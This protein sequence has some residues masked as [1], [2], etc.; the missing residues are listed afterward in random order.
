MYDLTKR[1]PIQGTRC[2][3]ALLWV[4]GWISVGVGAVDARTG[5][6]ADQPYADRPLL[7]VLEELRARGLTIFFTSQLIQGD[8]R[9]AWE[10]TATDPAAMLDEILAP[11][12]LTTEDGPGGRRVVI[13]A[14][15]P[16]R[17]RGL[18]LQ[19]SNGAPIPGVQVLLPEYGLETFTDA[20]G[21]FLLEDTPAGVHVVE[22]RS[23]GFIVQ[24]VDAVKVFEHGLSQVHFI[25]DAAPMAL[26]EIVVTPSQLSIL[27]EEPVT[28]LDLNRD[29]FLALP[30]LGD[31][32]F[33]TFTLLPGISGEETSARFNIRGGR[34]DEVLVLLDRV[35][36]FEPYHLKDFNGALS[37]V[38]PRALQEVNLLT[39]GFPAQYGDRMSGVLD[40]SSV[41]GTTQRRTHFALN[42]LTAEASRAESFD[43]GRG[44]WLAS[45]RGGTLEFTLDL[46]DQ[47]DRPTYWDI[48]TKG[49]YQLKPNQRIGMRLLHSADAL[50]L[51]TLEESDSE[52]YATSYGNSYLWLDYQSILGEDLF[53]DTLFSV[54][55]VRRD[56]QGREVDLE[57]EEGFVITDN[58]DFDVLGF[59]QDW[60]LRLGEQHYVR[61][62]F[63]ARRLEASYDYSNRFDTEDPF[64]EFRSEPRASATDFEGIFEGEQYSAYLT[65][66]IRWQ[67]NLT[68][69]LGLRYDENSV[70]GDRDFSPR[71]NLLYNAGDRSSLRLAWGLFFQSQ[72]PYELQVEDGETQLAESERT[73]HW[74]LGYE[75]AFTLGP[76]SRDMLL[77]IEAYRRDTDNPRVRFE[78][79]F[80]P[81]SNFPEVDIDRFRIAPESSE[82]HGI[83]VFLRG[84]ASR[85][86]DFW[87]SYAY[88]RV[89]DRLG[90]RDVP[91]RIDQPHTVNLDFH[92]RP[93]DR[94]SLNLGWRYHTGWP[95]TAL[96]GQPVEGGDDDE[97]TAVL[98]P[99]NGER[100][101]T[102]HRLDLR[103]SRQWQLR[104][105]T[106]DLFIDVQN[107]YDR[108][109]VAGIDLE[110]DFIFDSNGQVVLDSRS[111][112]IWNGILPTVG[113]V[114]EF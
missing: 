30:S 66:R 41:T 37:I 42:A 110:F 38:A 12:G 14:R 81:V 85:T 70:T 71:F 53:V 105:G 94:W 11:Y 96:G 40:M 3:A 21:H 95:I 28:S 20:D 7:E 100:L 49:D 78:N 91:R 74:V 64:A 58:R 92:W 17:I 89:T 54:G 16:A 82:A 44:H 34:S 62:G 111:N 77:R 83:E 36:L 109:N 22:A 90:E 68:V 107:L 43:G 8:M 6:Y 97:F 2:L 98:G 106:L 33:R 80:E 87:A 26:D 65:D 102:Y 5:Q 46:L 13:P 113:L 103:L 79:I 55:R 25:L 61:W 63:D 50:D 29:D 112:E 73:E 9:V 39:G 75:R 24:R 69:E 104:R 86:V 56:R 45:L 52:N 10:P 32:V 19:R 1:G 4:L 47:P 59:E 114:W 31:D 101:P 35:E 27:R 67:D 18:V 48:F 72:R 99:L 15:T 84:S 60:S 93:N 23:P 51:N 108:Q 88:A 76:R 57:D